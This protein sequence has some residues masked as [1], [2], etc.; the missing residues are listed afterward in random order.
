MLLLSRVLPLITDN[1]LL[2]SFFETN[3]NTIIKKINS[4]K[5]KKKPTRHNIYLTFEPAQYTSRQLSSMSDRLILSLV[6]LPV[7]IIYLIL[8]HQEDFTI[9]CSMRNVC[10]RLNA[11]VD[12]YRR[13]Q[14]NFFFILKVAFPSTFKNLFSA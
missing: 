9:V 6:T 4:L 2:Y 12:S 1:I 3:N 8:D 10:Q 14:V 5:T 7:E 11:I 13:Y